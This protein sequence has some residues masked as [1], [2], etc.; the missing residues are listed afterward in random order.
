MNRLRVA[1]ADLRLSAFQTLN[2]NWNEHRVGRT[3]HEAAERTRLNA[4][5]PADL[6]SADGA[7]LPELMTL[8]A[9]ARHSKRNDSLTRSAADAYRR[10][11]VGTGITC[12]SSV[13]DPDTGDE[14][15][16]LNQQI[17]RAWNSWCNDPRRCDIEGRKTFVE[18]QG[19]AIEEWFTVG[20]SFVVEVVHPET[21][22]F[23]VAVL[24]S[25]QLARDHEIPATQNAVR[26]GVEIDRYGRPLA[27]WF[28][29]DHHPLEHYGGIPTRIPADRVH[30]LM[31]QERSRQ[32]R[33]VSRL[34]TV[35]RKLRELALYD[36]YTVVRAKM[37]ACIG[38]LIH[39]KSPTDGAFDGVPGV[40]SLPTQDAAGN[41]YFD[42]APGMVQR[43]STGDDVTTLD[44]KTPGNNYQPFTEKQEKQIAAGVGLDYP[45]I[46]RDFSNGSFSAQREGHIERDKETD[47]LQQLMISLAIL[48]VRRAFIYWAASV[49]KIQVPEW[50]FDHD[51]EEFAF[52]ANVQPPPKPWIDPAKQSAGAK[53]A[54]ELGLSTPQIEANVLGYDYREL[55]QQIRDYRKYAESIGLTPPVYSGATKAAP[56]EPRPTYGTEPGENGEVR[57][58]GGKLNGNGRI[59]VRFNT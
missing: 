2:R 49:G 34:T 52:S 51:L 26:G 29:T 22:Q 1:E 32:T 41:P 4:D 25:E 39:R 9:R 28:H 24:E 38:L 53:I 47:P 42:M 30:H 5:W 58:N 7:L 57:G 15:T 27:Y 12:R 56:Q 54:M 8:V 55:L 44:P 18:V 35:L 11:V 3:A 46:T 17:D 59:P 6:Y 33:G 45:T 21:G 48:P 14:L 20:E 43:L 37:E 23:H 40:P 16:A 13:R 36:S 50:F 19:M 10:H 31:R